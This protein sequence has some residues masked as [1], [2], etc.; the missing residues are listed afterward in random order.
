MNAV[1]KMLL[2]EAPLT[3]TVNIHWIFKQKKIIFTRNWWYFEVVFDMECDL[4]NCNYS[5]AWGGKTKSCL[6][7]IKAASVKATRT[8]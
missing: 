3:N 6:L 8:I 2:R 7:F 1:E 5:K 4:T